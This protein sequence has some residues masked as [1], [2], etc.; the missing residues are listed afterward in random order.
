MTGIARPIDQDVLTALCDV[1][2]Y[3]SAD[4]SKAI[5][6]KPSET[7][8]DPTRD[9]KIEEFVARIV[10]WNYINDMVLVI[11][12]L[13]SSDDLGYSDLIKEKLETTTRAIV[14]NHQI[15]RTVSRLFKTHRPDEAALLPEIHTS[16]IDVKTATI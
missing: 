3:N 15:L 10:R 5:K 7:G 9:I 8:G 4:N 14:R 6:V 13:A 12:N 1:A 16:A 11:K 2:I